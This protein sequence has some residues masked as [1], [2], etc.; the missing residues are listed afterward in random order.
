MVRNT[1]TPAAALIDLIEGVTSKWAKQRKAEERDA[2]AR[3]RRNDAMLRRRRVTIKE[4][5]EQVLPESYRKASANHTLP[6]NARQIYYAARKCILASTDRDELDSNYF[7]QVLLTNYVD[8][9]VLNWDIVWDDRGHFVEPHTRR[10]IGLGTLAVR[11]YISGDKKPTL[12]EPSLASAKVDTQGPCGRFGAIL[13]VEKEGFLPILEAARIA[14]RYDVAIMSSKGVSVT[15]A[16]NLIDNLSAKYAVPVL[17][18]HDFDIAGFVICATI[19][20][21]TRRYT[22]ENEV[23]VRDIGLRLDDVE[24]LDLESEHVAIDK[25]PL[26]LAHTLREN[27]ATDEEIDF[28]LSGR[29]V[30]LNAMTSDQFVEFVERKLEENEVEKVIPDADQLAESFRL[31]KRS[32]GLEELIEKALAEHEAAEVTIPPDLGDRVRN[33]LESNPEAPW[34]EALAAIADDDESD[35]GDAH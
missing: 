2:A 1:T 18:L 3:L 7:C 23:D 13:F 5:A 22:F 12:I 26:R 19:S 4:A 17:V 32:K 6:A 8:E 27:G 34:D 31:F 35:E 16:R 28:L 11:G 10:R 9:H 20:S 24:E 33:Y 29:R 25:N 21:D 30:E 14:E 15:A